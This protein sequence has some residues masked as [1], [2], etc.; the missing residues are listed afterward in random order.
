MPPSASLRLV[1][2]PLPGP[3]EYKRWRVL[4]DELYA[5]G[6]TPKLTEH[7]VK[8]VA[9]LSG[10]A[11]MTLYHDGSLDMIPQPDVMALDSMEAFLDQIA[12]WKLAIDS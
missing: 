5:W 10:N 3:Q 12:M 2:F 6:F 9:T 1:R 4:Y 8:Y 7:Q 11:H